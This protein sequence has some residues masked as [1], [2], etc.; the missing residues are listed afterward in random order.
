M[1]SNKLTILQINDTHGYLEE[2]QEM[3]WD[4]GG[5]ST[6]RSAVMRVSAV[7]LNRF[8]ASAVLIRSLRSTTATLCTALFRR[9]IRKAKRLSSRSMC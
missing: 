4:A 9:F 3:F 7:I 1:G 8:A 2:H 6:K 5:T